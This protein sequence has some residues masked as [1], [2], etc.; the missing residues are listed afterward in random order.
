M[1]G[2][3]GGGR[4][5]EPS[6]DSVVARPL[7]NLVTSMGT[8]QMGLHMDPSSSSFASAPFV[9]ASVAELMSRVYLVLLS[10]SSGRSI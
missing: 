6:S 1:L 7:P 2:G 9:Y 5:G 10:A 4:E 8:Q 3:G